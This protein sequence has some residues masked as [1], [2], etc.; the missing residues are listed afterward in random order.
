M[1][2]TSTFAN[3]G[4]TVTLAPSGILVVG[5]SY[6]QTAGTTVFSGGA[7]GAGAHVDIQGGVV[8][9]NLLIAGTVRN[10]GQIDVGGSGAAGFAIILGSFTQTAGGVLNVEIGGPGFLTQSDLLFVTGSAALGGTMNISLIGGYVP[11]PSL[12]FLPI[13][14]SSRTGDFATINGLT[15]AAGTRGFL[16]LLYGEIAYLLITYS[17]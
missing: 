6:V 7:L 4:G 12:L 8:T 10:A 14:F 5:G 1:P 2:S 15:Y 16:P 17:L 3:S 13:L 9:G 11:S